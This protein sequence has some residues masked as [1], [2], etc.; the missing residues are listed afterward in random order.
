MR[1]ELRLDLV[2]HLRGAGGDDGDAAAVAGVV[3]LGHGQAV[4]VV[5]AP[6]EEADDAGQHAGLVVDDH[7]EGVAIS[8]SSEFGR[9]GRR[10]NGWTS[11]S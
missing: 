7:G 5:A 9:G 3:D 10:R 2:D 4:D 6:R 11:L 1:L 8:S